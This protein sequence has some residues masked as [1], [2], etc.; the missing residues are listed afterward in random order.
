MKGDAPNRRFVIEFHNLHFFLDTTRRI[1]AAIVLQENGETR[2]RPATWRT[3]GV[4]EGNSATLGIENAT[5]TVALRY[6]FNE[7]VLAAEPAV[8]SIR[9][10]PPA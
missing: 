2:R 6:S 1:D 5:G 9:Y 4:S 8:K 10:L 7:A 3:T